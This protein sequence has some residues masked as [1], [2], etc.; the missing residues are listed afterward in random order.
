MCGDL[1]IDTAAGLATPAEL[2]GSAVDAADD[3]LELISVTKAL[4]PLKRKDFIAITNQLHRKLSNKAL[5]PERRVVAAAIEKL[6]IDWNVLS[7]AQKDAAI[8]AFNQALSGLVPA[9]MTAH[10]ILEVEAKSV[11]KATKDATI[12]KFKLNVDNSFTRRDA[13]VARSVSGMHG[14]IITDEAGRIVTSTTQ[15]A[16]ATVAEMIEMGLPSSTIAETL[17]KGA[18]ART[19]G[20]ASNYWRVVSTAFV[21][22]ARAHEQLVTYAEAQIEYY[23]WESVMDERTTEICRF[24]HGTRF[25]TQMAVE[26]FRAA[27]A[28]VQSRGAQGLKD[29]QPWMTVTRNEAGK[30]EIVVRTSK[31][32]TSIATVEEP[33]YGEVDRVGR[34]SGTVDAPTLESLGVSTPPAHGLCRSTIVADF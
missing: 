23:I 11:V 33:G 14:N 30:Q 29:T 4:D 24:M 10:P 20:K 7:A 1:Y 15:W 31:G 34:Y 27:E 28:A 25:T 32:E 19:L 6:D 9:R 26:Q 13:A 22:R 16:R 3:V 5:P 12:S 21:G 2:Y 8:D 18:S 17:S